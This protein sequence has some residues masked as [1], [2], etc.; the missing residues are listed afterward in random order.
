VKNWQTL[1][2]VGLMYVMRL[3][4][5][6]CNAVGVQSNYI[7]G[8]MRTY[9]IQ[10]YIFDGTSTE[11]IL[12]GSPHSPSSVLILITAFAQQLRRVAIRI[13]TQNHLNQLN[14]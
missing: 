9:Q 10:D 11:R 4:F 6:I 3:A 8:W 1:L 7:V 13:E 5:D 14:C 12:E 2:V